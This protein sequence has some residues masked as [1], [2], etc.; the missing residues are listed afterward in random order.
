MWDIINNFHLV[1]VFVS[2]SAWGTW[3]IV[4]GQVKPRVVQN[5]RLGARLVVF[6]NCDLYK[7]LC[8]GYSTNPLNPSHPS[9][10][11]LLPF[12]YSPHC[13][14]V[15]IFSYLVSVKWNIFDLSISQQISFHLGLK[16]APLNFK[17]IQLNLYNTFFSIPDFFLTLSGSITFLNCCQLKTYKITYSITMSVYYQIPGETCITFKD[18]NT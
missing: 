12:R 11:L 6:A 8:R 5:T 10:A 3:L 16:R 17:P 13:S 2:S 1:W 15:S 7:W 4:F 9:L 14:H 18:A